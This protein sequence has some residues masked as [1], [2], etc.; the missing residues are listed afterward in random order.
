M[1]KLQ[2]LLHQSYIT[3]NLKSNLFKQEASGADFR[4][5]DNN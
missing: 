3:K 5:I 4:R 2:D 1:T